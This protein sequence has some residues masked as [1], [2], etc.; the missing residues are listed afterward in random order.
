MGRPKKRRKTVLSS[1]YE[2]AVC[3]AC[4]AHKNQL[5]KSSGAPYISHPI[6][7]SSLVLEYGG[8]E[9]QAIGALL[10]DVIEDCG[11][12]KTE[13]SRLFGKRVAVIVR[14]CTDYFGPKAQKK[15][16]WKER[17]QAYIT[18]VATIERSSLLVSAAD[19][20]HNARSI[21]HDVKHYG[22]ETW[23]KFNASPPEI[24]WY[25]RTI[26]KAFRARKIVELETLLSELDYWIDELDR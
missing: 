25:Y 8:D 21:A 24:I 6:A 26:S 20:L 5:R 13:L 4:R 23:K 15:P 1:R 3:F 2:R 7:V 9:H 11:V 18:R 10:H 19:K 14:D 16:P 22:P 12:K 17:K